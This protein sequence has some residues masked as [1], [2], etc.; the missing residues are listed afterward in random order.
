MRRVD[1]ASM[2]SV[3]AVSFQRLMLATAEPSSSGA[4]RHADAMTSPPGAL[5][6]MPAGSAS[7]RQAAQAAQRDVLAALPRLLSSPR[8]CTPIRAAAVLSPAPSSCSPASVWK[9]GRRHLVCGS[10]CEGLRRV[11]ACLALC[12]D[13]L[14]AFP[15][16]GEAVV[17]VSAHPASGGALPG[18]PAAPAAK[19]CTLPPLFSRPTTIPPATTAHCLCAGRRRLR[20]R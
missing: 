19:T 11:K 9:Q 6:T 7:A 1:V 2:R 10:H 20:V 4:R 13:L 5:L 14:L 17:V 12:A 8:P 16:S 3:G 18:S 15:A